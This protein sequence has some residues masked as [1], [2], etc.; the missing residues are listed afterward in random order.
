MADH[1]IEIEGDAPATLDFSP[2]FNC[3]V[4]MIDRHL[5]EGR[6]DRIAIRETSGRDVTYG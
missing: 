5:A 6:A 1:T 2:V 4:Y 3:A